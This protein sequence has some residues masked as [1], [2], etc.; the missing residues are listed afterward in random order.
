MRNN[1]LNVI[2]DNRTGAPRPAESAL[3][4][5]LLRTM[6]LDLVGGGGLGQLRLLVF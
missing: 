5:L 1:V 6:Y 3:T 2:P 4:T